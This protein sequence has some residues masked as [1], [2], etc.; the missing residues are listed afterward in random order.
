MKRTGAQIVWESL[1][2]EGAQYVFGYPGGAILPTY[3]AMLDYPIHH[4]LVRHEQGATH[5]LMAGH[6]APEAARGGPIAAVR[7][8]DMIVFDVNARRLDLD[9]P[10]AEIH[11]RM[12]KW[13]PPT[14][15]YTVGVMAK[16]ANSVSSAS[17]GAVTI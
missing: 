3:D 15:R 13:Q 10:D 9:V 8:G 7:D 5:G 4:V 11:A 17:T 2:R 6:V 16:Y 1:V 12:S 14:P